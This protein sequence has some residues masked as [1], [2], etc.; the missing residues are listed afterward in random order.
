MT[1]PPARGPVRRRAL[2]GWLPWVLLALAVGAFIWQASTSA[3]LQ[4]DSFITYRYARNVAR[5]LGPVFNPGERVEGYTNFLWMMMLAVLALIGL[6]FTVIIPLSQ[7]IGVLCGIGTVVLFCL[8]LRRHGTGP[9]ALAPVAALLLGLN[10][11]FSYWHV[12]GME[13]GLFTFL[14]AAA[15]WYWLKPGDR[16]RDLVSASTLL[17]LSALTR[18]EGAMFFALFGLHYV[19]RRL[20]ARDLLSRAGLGR[21]GLFLLPFVVLVAPLYAWRLGWYGYLFPNTFYAKTGAS[22]AYFKAGVEYLWFFLR[23]Y[24]LWGAAFVVPVA[25]AAWRNRL[26]PADPLFFCLLLLVAHALYVVWVGG[27]VLR[28]WRFFVPV[29]L[30]F[31]FLLV[32]GIWL[33]PLP[34]VVRAVLLLALLPLTFFG[35]FISPL[36]ARKEIARNLELEKGLVDK[37]TATGRWLNAKLDED[38][39]F[40]CT[41]IGAVSYYSDRNMVDMLGLTDAVIAHQPE[42]ILESEWHWKERN[43]NTAH[44]LGRHPVYVYFSTGVKPSAEAERALF[45]R[46]RFRRGYFACPVTVTGRQNGQLYQFTETIYKARPGADTIPLEPVAEPSVFINHYLDGINLLRVGTDTAA[47]L[48]RR[49]IAEAPEDFGA[50]WEWLGRIEEERRRPGAAETHYREA[51]RR[52]DWLITTHLSLARILYGRGDAGGAAGHLAKV[53]EY[54]PDFLEGHAGLHAMLNAVGDSAGAAALLVRINARFPEATGR[55]R[56]QPRP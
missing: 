51:L 42:A 20:A 10:G 35:P 19:I 32:E 21:L 33:L 9:P 24:G 25:L 47:A 54:A 6:P 1:R 39:W 5:G 48:F 14:L 44:V 49:C 2:P 41:T 34:R 28:N 30:P 29:L 4:D 16:A 26:R 36:T 52:D 40:A 22:T 17:G 50:P 11:A 8:L 27:D 38:D 46:P 13:T 43:Y 7:V 53:V 3:F 12:S 15:A 23:A 56:Q 37:M 45:L 18:P 55:A 31:Y